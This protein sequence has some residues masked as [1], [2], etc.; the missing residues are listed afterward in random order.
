MIRRSFTKGATSFLTRS[1]LPRCQC[2]NAKVFT[3]LRT[4]TRQYSDTPSSNGEKPYYVTSPIFYVNA[5]TT[6]VSLWSC[7]LTRVDSNDRVCIAPHVGHLYTMIITDVLKR[8]QVLQGRKAILCT[9]TDEHGMKVHDCSLV[10]F[11]C[12]IWLIICPD[13][14]SSYECGTRS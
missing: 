4:T 8:W 11:Q 12:S 2:H 5:G 14:T 9:G 7:F 13:P 6:W 10:R 3:P 1:I